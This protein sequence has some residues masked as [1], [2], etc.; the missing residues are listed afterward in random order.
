MFFRKKE[1]RYEEICAPI[2]GEMIPLE[3]VRD[4]VFSQ[5]LVGDG[6]AFSFDGNT[7]CSP[8]D[9]EIT[10]IA[11]TKH[12]FGFRTKKGSELLLHVGLDTVN[13]RGR[14]FH[15]MVHQ[16]ERVRKGYPILEIDRELMERD[17]IDLTVILLFIPRENRRME[18]IG[19]REVST[20]STVM[21]IEDV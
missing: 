20:E 14:G 12:A 16:N 13:L 4:E 2:D 15:V 17:G 5:K 3:S 7:V 8:C 21:R 10:L 6:V 19:N 11:P 9:G 1:C 18:I